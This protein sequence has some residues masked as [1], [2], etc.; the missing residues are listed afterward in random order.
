[1]ISERA[2]GTD[3]RQKYLLTVNKK[4]VAEYR[5]IK[6]GSSQNGLRVVESGIQAEDRVIVNGLLRVRPGMTVNPH[7]E[8]KSI[9]AASPANAPKSEKPGAEQ[10]T[11]DYAPL[12]R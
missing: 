1:M 7:T 4:N 11:A 8:E 9:A 5:P 12:P 10:A 6:L 3:Q 2:I